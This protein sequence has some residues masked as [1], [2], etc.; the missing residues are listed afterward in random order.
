[1]FKHVTYVYNRLL[2]DQYFRYTYVYTTLPV[3]H[4]PF[5]WGRLT[6]NL[7]MVS[8]GSPGA[9]SGSETPDPG[10]GSR[11]LAL[12]ILCLIFSSEIPISICI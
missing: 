12:D 6:C 3:N 10:T 8:S 5:L 7:M 1:M 9:R 2:N 4:A 11:I